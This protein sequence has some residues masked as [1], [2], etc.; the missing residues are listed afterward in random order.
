MVK[1]F[2]IVSILVALRTIIDPYTLYYPQSSPLSQH[3]LG[4]KRNTKSN[5]LIRIHILQFGKLHKN[6]IYNNQYEYKSPN[7]A[8]PIKTALCPPSCTYPHNDDTAT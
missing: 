3:K 6:Y 7:F 1:Y 2:G 8:Q 4:M 5:Y